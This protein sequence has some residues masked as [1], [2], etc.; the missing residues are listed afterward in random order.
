MT[1]DRQHT[2][3]W[4]IFGRLAAVFGVILICLAGFAG[5]LHLTGNFHTVIEGRVY[6]AAQISPENLE[7][8]QTEHGIA[9]VLNLRG[10]N[11]G[12]DWY[13]AEVEAS[14]RLGITHIDFRMASSRKLDQEQAQQLIDLMRDAPKPLLIHCMGGADRTGLAS[15]LYLA[16]I[17][18]AG[19]YAAEKQLSP[20]Y[21]HIVMPWISRA[22]A[23]DE[24]WE[25][26][27]PWLGFHDS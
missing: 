8:W 4:R 10:E 7:K 24:T 1:N 14:Q 11:T 20:R 17:E 27:E 9:T 26:L 21:G 6:R 15:A 2:R 25:N 5:Y 18:G 12:K 13:D 19:E 23:M 16:A 3:M 22:F